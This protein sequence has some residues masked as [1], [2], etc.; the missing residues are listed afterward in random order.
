MQSN[1]TKDSK[2]VMGTP[3][4]LYVG[5][6]KW[7][8]NGY[9]YLVRDTTE[10]MRTKLGEIFNLWRIGWHADKHEIAKKWYISVIVSKRQFDRVNFTVEVKDDR[11]GRRVEGQG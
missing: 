3:E 10:A 7:E 4:A 2:S 8:W 9:Q 5:G 1:S 6:L 11:L